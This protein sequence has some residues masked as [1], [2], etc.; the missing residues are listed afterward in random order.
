VTWTVRVAP[1]AEAEL[2]ASAR[3][4]DE[5]AGLRASFIEAIDAALFAI[6]ESPQ[7][8]PLWGP[9]SPYRTLLV[10][11]FPDRVVYRLRDDYVEILAFVHT[12][13]RPGYWLARG[14]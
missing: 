1:G 6:A 10:A 4:Y 13:R 9:R 11:R 3:W 7:R 8:H 14:Q 5:R 12:R 2:E